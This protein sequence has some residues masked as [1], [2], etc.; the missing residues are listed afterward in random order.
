M[1][2][3]R[4]RAV[5]LA[6]ITGHVVEVEAHLTASIP[7]FALVGLPDASLWESRDRVRA[8]IGSTGIR[9]PPRKIVVNLSPASLPKYGSSFDVAIAM[10]I[11]VGDGLL[12]EAAVTNTVFLG[13]LGLDGRIHPVKGILPAITAAM[14]RGFTKFVVPKGNLSEAQLVTGAQVLG[15]S[16]L[17]RVLSHFGVDISVPEVYTVDNA[18]TEVLEPESADLCEV[19]GQG[20]ARFALEVAAAGGHHLLLVGPPGTGKTMLAARLPGILPPLTE[21]ESLE[22]TSLHSIAGTFDPSQGLIICP[23]F[24]SPHHTATPAAIIGG[25][26][27]R[28]KPG[29]V[30]LAHRGVLFMDEAPEFSPRVLQTLRQPIER[31]QL[32]ISRVNA[33]AIFPAQFQLVLAANPC[34]CGLA[35]GRPGQCVC[36]SIQRRRYFSR[37]SGPLLDRIDLQVEVLPVTGL[38][39]AE[40]G[41]A[42]S[43][44]TVLKRVK[45]ARLAA[46]K[47]LSKTAWT[48]NSQVSGTWLRDTLGRQSQATKEVNRAVE[49]GGLTLRG[50]DR[51]LRVAWT[52]ADLEGRESPTKDHVFQALFLRTRGGFS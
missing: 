39:V 33:T 42:E 41:L 26:S 13:E 35:L 50:A 20:P 4:A 2:L 43:S 19:I 9:F 11:L 5:A 6:G 49:T 36:T 3:G 8:A 29:A 7:G 14:K 12:S 44:A 21:Q 46:A 48:R 27:G 10:A 45:Q 24:Q 51:V 22:V 32:V 15:A 34:P 52:L 47:R 38:E 31:G 37:I 1:V 25:G 40:R 28:P 23:P 18:A 16:S 17:A 30:S